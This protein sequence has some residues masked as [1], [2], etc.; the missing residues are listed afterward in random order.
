MEVKIIKEEDEYLELMLKD[1]DVGFSNLIVEKLI[2]SKGVLFAASAYE[3]PLRG[4]PVIK[5]KAKS[6]KKELKGAIEAVK[7]DIEKFS[8]ALKKELK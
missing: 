7:E 1:E 4:N 6:P 8:K 2:E 3:H 5:I